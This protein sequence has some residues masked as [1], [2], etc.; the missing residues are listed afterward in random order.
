MPFFFRTL[1]RQAEAK[2]KEKK[3]EA[4]RKENKRP[5]LLYRALILFSTKW[6]QWNAILADLAILFLTCST[7]G[8]GSTKIAN[9]PLNNAATAPNTNAGK[10][11]P[12]N[13]SS[14]GPLI[15][16]TSI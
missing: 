3:T 9:I 1:P 5:K 16:D 4:K 14:H 12:P 15:T 6:F 13:R 8:D 11:P 7:G 2:R 10:F